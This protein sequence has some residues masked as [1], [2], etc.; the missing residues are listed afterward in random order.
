MQTILASIS[1]TILNHQ[2][3]NHNIMIDG[4]KCWDVASS[5][6]DDQVK[7]HGLHFRRNQSGN[8]SITGSIHKFYNE[9]IHNA[10]DFTLGK[11]KLCFNYL[12]DNFLI[13]PSIT[14][15]NSVE[16]GVN[17]QL[18]FNPD[19]ALQSIL[20]YKNKTGDRGK[21]NISFHFETYYLKV[22]S[23]SAIGSS[24]LFQSGNILRIEIHVN[25]MRFFER[26]K[27]KF[28]VLS[29]I[30]TE[31][32]FVHF[33]QILKNAVS[34]CIMGYLTEQDINNLTEE[35][36]SFYYKYTN[37]NYLLKLQGSTKHRGINKLEEFISEHSSVNL[38]ELLI[39]LI[40]DKCVELR[41]VE[42]A[43]KIETSWNQNT[44]NFKN[45]PTK[46]RCYIS[47]SQSKAY[48]SK[49]K[50]N[51]IQIKGVFVPKLVRYYSFCK[52]CGKQI[53]NPRKDQNFCS[54]TDVGKA[55]A[56]SCRDRYKRPIE[57]V[58]KQY[59]KITRHPALF[60]NNQFI[61]PDY[62]TIL[63]RQKIIKH[64]KTTTIKR[65]Q[66]E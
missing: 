17:I 12:Y 30:V 35:Q 66:H 25:K 57:R 60:D 51:T 27:L 21:D 45:N 10:D 19:I 43:N 32:A 26:Y 18:P 29:D 15:P 1:K 9:G 36:S 38:K 23:K 13:N 54:A 5:I 40:Q 3:S 46:K 6:E 33:E 31:D 58:K 63:E 24:N 34:D 65:E 53:L 52:A 50:E 49:R 11:A 37:P 22:Y 48:T 62:M 55:A 41:D 44:K 56:Q 61:H 14:K 47:T 8:H 4:I 59:E 2:L 42:I 20:L 16:F 39:N 28:D 7:V 64:K